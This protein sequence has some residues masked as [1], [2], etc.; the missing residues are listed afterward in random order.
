MTDKTFQVVAINGN[1][2][3]TKP[4]GRIFTLGQR[5]EAEKFAEQMNKNSCGFKYVVAEVVYN[6]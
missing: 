2:N 3:V 1:N 4:W 5:S 6:Y